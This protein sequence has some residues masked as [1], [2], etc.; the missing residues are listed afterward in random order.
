[1][2]RFIFICHIGYEKKTYD[3][4]S[5]LENVDKNYTKIKPFCTDLLFIFLLK[6]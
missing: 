3:L 5:D 4:F 2:A 1:M 6:S